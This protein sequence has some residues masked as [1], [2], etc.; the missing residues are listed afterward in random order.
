MG[1]AVASIPPP[2]PDTVDVAPMMA[3]TADPR[4]TELSVTSVRRRL[5]RLIAGRM[6]VY[7]CEVARCVSGRRIA[8]NFWCTVPAERLGHVTAQLIGI[9]RPAGGQRC[10]ARTT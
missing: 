1:P 9:R 6:M 8:V 4:Q 10:P 5:A 3:L 7:R 2:T